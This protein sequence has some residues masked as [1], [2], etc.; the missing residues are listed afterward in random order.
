MEHA[1]RDQCYFSRWETQ[2]EEKTGGVGKER[3]DADFSFGTLWL[4]SL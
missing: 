1:S 4:S 3:G 2:K